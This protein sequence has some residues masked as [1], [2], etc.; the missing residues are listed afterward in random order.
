[1]YFK[2]RVLFITILCMV[3]VDAAIPVW[4]MDFK[5]NYNGV[6]SN[7]DCIK[8]HEPSDSRYWN[9]NYLCWVSE[10]SNPRL[11]Y[12][13]AGKISGMRCIQIAEPSDHSYW[14]DNW[15][16]APKNSPYNFIWS[17]A[18]KRRGKSCLKVHEPSEKIYWKDNW[19]CANYGAGSS[20][21]LKRVD[22]VFPNDFAW[23]Y[24]GGDLEGF[25]CIKIEEPSDKVW[26]DNYFCWKEGRNNPGMRWSFRGP[27]RG[28]RCTRIW[29][30]S[31]IGYWDDNYLCVPKSSALR[32]RWSYQGAL[33]DHSCIRWDEPS[34]PVWRDNYLCFERCQL[35]KLEVIDPDQYNTVYEGT[36]LL[37]SVSGA[38]CLG[39]INQ[40]HTLQ[41][42]SVDSVTETIGV[43]VARS[44]EINWQ[45][46]TSVSLE[47]SAKIFGSGSSFTVETSFSAGG[48][49]GYSRAESNDFSKG[50][51]VEVGATTTYTTPG[52]AIIF[53]Q[54]NRYKFDQSDIPA[55]MHLTCPSGGSFV[56]ETTIK[57]QATT[58]QSAHFEPLIGS[59]TPEACRNDPSI[60]DCVKLLG[61]QYD[62]FFGNMEVVR[63]AFRNCFHGKGRVRR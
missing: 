63:N 58:F 16:C 29:E 62:N 42:T 9:D 54:V 11:R 13:Y 25:D 4:P 27:I 15:L 56:K 8:I 19:L 12:S 48:S 38:N 3:S 22:P 49:H 53:G 2:V 26:M 39:Q 6:P 17:Y 20:N 40:E 7:Y 37:G 51:D 57:M 30:S 61:D 34:Y 28:M 46:S 32:F 35:T 24:N 10:R 41:M 60:V 23:S 36:Q 31:K 21:P 14:R 33:R 47:A 55:K 18:G 5:W 50:N 59:F 52:A 45:I 43:E 44:S 1:M